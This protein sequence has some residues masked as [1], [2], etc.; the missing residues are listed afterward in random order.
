MQGE[1]GHAKRSSGF[2]LPTPR[3]SKLKLKVETFIVNNHIR[4][5]K[6]QE[7]F[8]DAFTDAWL[9]RQYPHLLVPKCADA[10]LKPPLQAFQYLPPLEH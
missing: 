1:T 2:F 7:S 6:N 8:T 10:F 5:K 4:R 9:T 3:Y